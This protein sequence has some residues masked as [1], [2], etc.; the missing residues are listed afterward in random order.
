MIR[1]PPI[2]FGMW[3]SIYMNVSLTIGE[4]VSDPMHD[5]W[6]CQ[7]LHTWLLSL[8]LLEECSMK[9]MLIQDQH[10][11]IIFFQQQ[12]T[13]ATIFTTMCQVPILY[14]CMLK[15]TQPLKEETSNSYCETVPHDW[16]FRWVNFVWN[17]YFVNN[18]G[19]TKIHCQLCS[20]STI[21]LLDVHVLCKGL[22]C[23]RWC[24]WN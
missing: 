5:H 6:G 21:I 16:S 11:L 4:V 10:C 7:I 15:N 8:E 9:Q 23:I 14:W 24:V 17:G 3:G 2:T 19:C 20:V 13:Y 18:K 1:L 22:C 12:N